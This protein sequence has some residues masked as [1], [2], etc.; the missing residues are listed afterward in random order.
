MVIKK[1]IVEVDMLKG[2]IFENNEFI[3][4]EKGFL[5]FGGNKVWI[6]LVYEFG[7]EF[8]EN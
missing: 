3:Y 8:L 5:V 7:V 1:V 4:G 2:V 6:E